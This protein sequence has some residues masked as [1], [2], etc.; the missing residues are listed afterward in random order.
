VLAG[1]NRQAL[2]VA[3]ACGASFIRAEGFVFAHVAD[4]G[5]MDRADAGPLLRYRRQIGA[6]D[7]AILADIKKKHSSHALTADLDLAQTA[8]AA[9]FFGAGGLVVTGTV[10]GQ[11]ADPTDV[12]STRNAVRLPVLIG[13][14][15][16]PDNLADYWQQADAFIVGSYIK[17]EGLWSNP[18]DRQR[19]ENVVRAARDLIEA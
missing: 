18:P 15:I 14:G 7:I 9:E 10:T 5:L 17:K 19:A 11:P 1:A 2:A 6:D 16:T 12:A 4:E 8:H 3:Q 13:S